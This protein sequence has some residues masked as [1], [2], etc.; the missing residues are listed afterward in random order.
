MTFSLLPD[1]LAAR[2]PG[3]L[4]EA[5]EAVA[6]AEAAPSLAAAANAVRADAVH[7]PGAMRWLRRR[8]RYVHRVLHIVRG[9]RPDLLLGCAAGVI[10]ARARL[11]T[12][13]ALVV[14][15]GEL[16]GQ[17]PRLPMPLGFCR[18]GPGGHGG[19]WHVQHKKGPDPPGPAS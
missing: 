15:R 4:R 1:C 19:A 6:A 2:L 5:E 16:A 12:D 8:V 14:L 13:I 3:T 11:Q 7:L 18:H 10:G 9:M 17:L